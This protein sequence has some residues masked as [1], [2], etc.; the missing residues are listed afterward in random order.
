MQQDMASSQPIELTREIVTPNCVSFDVETA[1]LDGIYSDELSAYRAKRIWRET[2]ESNFLLEDKADFQFSIT[3]SLTEGRFSLRCDFQTAC[4]RYAFWRITNNQA[5]EAQYIIETAH[6]PNSDSHIDDLMSAPD[7][8]SSRPS[9][10]SEVDGSSEY[11]ADM[12][13]FK[14]LLK[15]IMRRIHR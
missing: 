5:P 13:T 9:Y 14:E 2:L 10:L 7:M 1:S 12:L 8:R 4:G 6:I 15:A 3:K 11:G